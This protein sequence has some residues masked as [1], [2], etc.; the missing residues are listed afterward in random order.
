MSLYNVH[1]NSN[2]LVPLGWKIDWKVFFSVWIYF[3]MNSQMIIHKHQ[4]QNRFIM[5]DYRRLPNCCRVSGKREKM[6]AGTLPFIHHTWLST[7]IQKVSHGKVWNGTIV[8]CIHKFNWKTNAKC[9]R[10]VSIIP[11]TFAQF[12]AITLN[13]LLGNGVGVNNQINLS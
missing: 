12:T 2:T 9:R 10:N 8:C 4:K 6:A 13:R 1:L 5:K 3:R 7:K 11:A